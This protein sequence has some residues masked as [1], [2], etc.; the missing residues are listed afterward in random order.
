MDSTRIYGVHAVYEAL[1]SGRVPIE[2][3]H[4]GRGVG[5]PKMREI[6]DLARKGNIPV[7]ME[8]RAAIDRMAPGA[9]HQGVVAVAG[10]FPYAPFDA[11]FAGTG[12][13]LIV[14]L[15]GVEDPHNLGAVLR[16]ADACGVSG[17]LVPER[18]SAPL[19]PAV[20]KTAAGALAHVPVARVTNLV[21]ALE[22]L[23]SRGLWVVGV[24]PGGDRLWTDF[25]YAG[26]VAI[27]LG[28]EHK[29]IRRLVREHCD[30]LVRLPMRGKIA[31]L[32]ISVAAGVDLY[33]AARQ[34][35]QRGQSP[36]S[37]PR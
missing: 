31:S 6:L 7:R 9:R 21:R 23:K 5:V 20:S 4:V 25:D 35:E 17:V 32:N 2:R 28:G 36:I 33:E 34:R 13:P 15:D 19:G 16:T 14:V 3:I 1:A 8:D 22:D 30:A 26:P 27:A 10:A 12:P 18:H 29:G 11:L 37:P 24:D